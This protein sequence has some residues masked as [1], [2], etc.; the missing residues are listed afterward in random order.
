M[1]KKYKLSELAKDLKLSNGEIVECLEKLTGE[2]KKTVASL[3]PEEI[4]YVL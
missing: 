3:T 4:G 1:N 2:T